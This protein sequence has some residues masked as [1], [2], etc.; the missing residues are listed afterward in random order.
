MHVIGHP[1][2]L[3][4]CAVL[5]IVVLA[6]FLLGWGGE[7]GLLL[8]VL[9]ASVSGLIDG[10]LSVAVGLLLVA[11][12]P[13]LLMADQNA[14]LQQSSLVNYYV[15]SAGVYTLRNAADEV[16][17]WAYYFLAIGVVALIARYVVQ[18]RTKR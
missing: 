15:S 18:A 11:C 2:L 1:R 14:W 12:C 7:A 6:A 4:K 8:G 16:A 17:V 13:I 10:R 3:M 5:A 9:A